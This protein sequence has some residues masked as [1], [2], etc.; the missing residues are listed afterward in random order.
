MGSLIID[1]DTNEATFVIKGSDTA[2]LP[3][4]K[5][6]YERKEVEELTTLL[7][8]QGLRTLVYAQ[9]QINS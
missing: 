4:L 2:I 9:R 5:Y 7:A 8:K 3:F 6:E 1:I